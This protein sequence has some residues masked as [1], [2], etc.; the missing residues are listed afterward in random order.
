MDRN[1]YL[2][3]RKQYLPVVIKTIF[4]LESPPFSGKYFYNPNGKTTE[5]LFHAMMKYVLDFYPSSKEEGLIRF[6]EAGYILVDAIYGPVNNLRGRQ[7]DMRILSNYILLKDDLKGVLLEQKP[8]TPAIVL[9][10]ANV[11]K[12]LEQKLL[13]DGFNVIN[14]GLIVPFPAFGH[15]NEFCERIKVLLAK[16]I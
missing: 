1:Y 16:A 3:L 5:P 9:V 13:Q 7:R 4:I 10:K 15:Q 14:D 6:M 12:L 11:C 2:E 8:R